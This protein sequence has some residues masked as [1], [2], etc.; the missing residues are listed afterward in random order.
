MTTTEYD[1]AC[2]GDISVCKWKGCSVKNVTAESSTG[3]MLI[4]KAYEGT[5][6]VTKEGILGERTV[7][8]MVEKY[9]NKG[10]CVYF[11][12][13][14]TSFDILSDLLA[15]NTFAG[16][17]LGENLKHFPKGIM[18]NR[19]GKRPLGNMILHVVRIFMSANGKAVV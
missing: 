13:F 12:N 14:L 11:D 7:V 15:K 18:K 9:L 2:S 1:S 17:T 19:T 16:G 5:L 8:E 3:Y 10:Y 6:S 4:F